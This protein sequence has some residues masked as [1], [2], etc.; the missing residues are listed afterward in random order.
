M[1]SFDYDF[2]VIGAGSGG[3]RAA[4]TAAALGARTAVAEAQYLGGT[5]VNVGCIP[6]KLYTYAAHLTQELQ[7][8]SAFGWTL[9]GEADFDWA[10]LKA[11]KD[12]EISRLNGIYDNLLNNVNVTIH[13]EFATIAGPNLVRM[14]DNTV[15]ARHI[16][17]AVGGQPYVPPIPGAEHAM[18]SDDFFELTSRP[19]SVAIVGG[20]FIAT[21]L[22]GVFKG[23]GSKVT[24]IH[25]RDHLLTGF[26]EDIQAFYTDCA[27]ADFDLR[28]STEVLDIARSDSDSAYRLTLSDN[29]ELSTDAVLFA[30]GRKPA[31]GKLGLEALGV[32]L[33]DSGAIV[34][35]DD[36]ETAVPGIYAVGDVIDRVALTP[37]ALAEGQCLANRLF[38]GPRNAVSY[39]H[40]PSAVFSHPQIATVG[41]TESKA[42]QQ[43]TDILVYKSRFR[44]LKY[45]LS[46]SENFT[47]MK[48]IVDQ[49]SDRVIGLHMVGDD[50]AE[51]VQGMAVAMQAGAT[52]A[53]FD[54]TIGIHPTSAEEF[55]TMRTP[56]PTQ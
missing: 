16:L 26:D 56:E 52:K 38:G 37:V 6:K 22:A 24:L 35:N 13:R 4:R 25:R 54:A 36:F 43:F 50:A 11:N 27:R 42:R 46:R 3:V 5:C 41:L 33:T 21:E 48:M 40:I 18:T 28:L 1:Q 9:N 34:V 55:V 47:L 10:T 23:L 53:H 7:E 31:T 32:G 15:S 12:K 30:T 51:I 20:G 17:I 2:F 45:T 29:T 44:P 49:A 19:A 14:G 39:D 8:S